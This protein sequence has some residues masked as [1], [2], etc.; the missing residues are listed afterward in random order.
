[1]KEGMYITNGKTLV[2]KK[3]KQMQIDR[4]T[5]YIYGLEDSILLKCPH[6]PKQSTNSLLSPPKFQHFFLTEIEKHN[7]NVH[8]ET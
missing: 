6:Y 2:G 1:M 5:S 4:K 7:P 3:F 8:G